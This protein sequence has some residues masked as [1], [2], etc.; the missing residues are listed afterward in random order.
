MLA[1]HPAAPFLPIRKSSAKA[2]RLNQG[3]ISRDLRLRRSKICPVVHG[4]SNRIENEPN[5]GLR[6]PAKVDLAVVAGRL[7]MSGEMITGPF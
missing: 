6:I 7:G 4:S 1:L 3:R 2:V 5:Y